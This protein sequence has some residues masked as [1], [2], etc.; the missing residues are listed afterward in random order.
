MANPIPAFGWSSVVMTS[1][2]PTLVGESLSLKRHK[3]SLGAHRWEFEFTTPPL[4]LD[5]Q[6]DFFAFLGSLRG[7]LRP[8]DFIHPIYSMPRGNVPQSGLEVAGD[9]V[10]G[11][12]TVRI[13]GFTPEDRIAVRAGD[14]FRFS[15]HNKVYAATVDEVADENGIVELDIQQPL[16][17]DLSTDDPVTG[18]EVPFTLSLTDDTVSVD[19]DGGNGRLVEFS[20]VAVEE[21]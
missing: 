19:M 1:N 20:V 10:A 16:V 18:Y 2:T 4:N 9:T 13:K 17:K 12:T 5:Q 7:Q 3:R 6:R 15:N 21:I 11:S 8:F 14:L